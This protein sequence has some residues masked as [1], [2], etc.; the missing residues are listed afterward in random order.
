MALALATPLRDR[1]ITLPRL[2]L[3]RAGWIALAC[4]GL[5]SVLPLRFTA[6]SEL[7]FQTA[8]QPEASVVKGM[9]QV[10]HS[11]EM[12]LDVLR[13]L[14][15]QDVADLMGGAPANEAPVDLHA[16]RMKAAWRLM[17]GLDITPQDG[18]RTLL[19]AVTTS[20]SGRAARVANAY[21]RAALALDAKVRVE[22]LSA[23]SEALPALKAGALATPPALIDPPGPL[24]LAALVL[25]LAL[26]VAAHLKGRAKTEL[27]SGRIEAELL[28]QE[29]VRPPR[30]RWV[31]SSGEGDRE[32]ASL[33]E[34]AR[35]LR[36]A[37][38]AGVLI[39]LTSDDLPDAASNLAVALARRLAKE[40]RTVLVALDGEAPA[41]SALVADPRVPGM[42]ELLFGV[43][44][45]GE[46]IH[47]DQKSHAHLIPPGRDARGGDSVI[48]AE[49]LALILDSLRGTY[50][51]VVVA[52]PPLAGR[53]G[54]ERIARLAPLLVVLHENG[55]VD[56]FDTLAGQGFR[57]VLMLE[58]RTP[59]IPSN[60]AESPAEMA[61]EAPILGPEVKPTRKIAEPERRAA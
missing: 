47:R 36:G 57:R 19:L 55:G 23:P 25:S 18:G 49:R 11:R 48:G 13:I 12:A 7:A 27:P 28:P 54:A 10:V 16:R 34:I 5:L 26:L 8:I 61:P 21:A 6:Q 22:A 32:K 9:T 43:A 33:D 58:A 60:E 46:A 4:A 39:L 15:A 20:D 30:V 2:S 56:L 44:G 41:L 45:F 24:A 29:L 31:S 3:K 42:A 14:P 35:E 53:K 40:T 37:G 59:E 51:H 1:T 38:K 52:A 17:E 50:D